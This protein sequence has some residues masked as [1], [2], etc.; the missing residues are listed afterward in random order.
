ME[1]LYGNFEEFQLAL[2][3]VYGMPYGVG[4]DEGVTSPDNDPD[5]WVICPQCQ[6]PIYV[7]DQHEDKDYWDCPSCC[8][9]EDGED[10]EFKEDEDEDYEE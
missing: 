9:V 2:N 8:I 1:K 6:E 5:A 3:R 10:D 7:C 4:E